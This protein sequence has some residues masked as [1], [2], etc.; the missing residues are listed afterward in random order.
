MWNTLVGR[1]GPSLAADRSHRS[2]VRRVPPRPHPLSRLEGSWWGVPRAAK[3]TEGRGQVPITKQVLGT[4]GDFG[5]GVADHPTQL[6]IRPTFAFGT[7][8][9]NSLFQRASLNQHVREEVAN[10]TSAKHQW[11][12]LI[13]AI[14]PAASSHA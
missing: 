10:R 8:I 1:S 5:P 13:P 9:G 2:G 6:R 7:N 11:N 3:G 12:T 4:V 14:S